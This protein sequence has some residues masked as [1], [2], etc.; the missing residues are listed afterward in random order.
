MYFKNIQLLTKGILTFQKEEKVK[1]FLLFAACSPDMPTTAQMTA[2]LKQNSKPLVGGFFPQ[3]IAEGA[4]KEKGFLLI[5]VYE[6]LEV[7]IIEEH[8][9]VAENCFENVNEK[10]GTVFCFPNAFWPQKAKLMH[11]LYDALGPFMQ[12]VGGGAGALDFKSFPCV[13]VNQQV[14]ENGA[15]IACM[16]STVSIGV[17]HGWHAISESLKITKATKNRIETLNWKPAFQVY[18]EWVESHSGKSFDNFPFFDIAKSYP[19][20]LFRLDNEPVIRDP[21]DSISQELI[22]VDEVEEGNFVQIMHGDMHSLLEGAK[23]AVQ[24]AQITETE[25]NVT[26]L[27]FDCVSRVLFMEDNFEKEVSILNQYKK[28]NGVLS[29]GEIANAGNS[30]LE[31]FNKT[32]VV[33]QWKT[34][35]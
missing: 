18:K 5:A 9:I 2:L 24:V 35:S 4:L 32:V 16:K 19:L 1:G 31:L 15:A 25:N 10:Q 20:G 34:Q 29:I 17:A 14:V 27:C 22:L 7:F 26:Q 21:Y 30:T 12:Y 23:L 33:A 8:K 3:I 28:A 13:F 11:Q 6:E